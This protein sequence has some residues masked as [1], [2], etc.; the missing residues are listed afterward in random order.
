VGNLS[1]HFQREQGPFLEIGWAQD[2]G[3]HDNPPFYT[4]FCDGNEGKSVDG[5]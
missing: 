4:G 2:M 1:G 5:F 3:E